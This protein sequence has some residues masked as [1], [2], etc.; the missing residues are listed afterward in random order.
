M[1]ETVTNQ[2]T[3]PSSELQPL[4]YGKGLYCS[5]Q[6]FLRYFAPF[7]VQRRHKSV[8]AGVGISTSLI[9]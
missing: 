1:L 7:S 9:L 8:Y 6:G 5:T 3:L 4:I 2:Y